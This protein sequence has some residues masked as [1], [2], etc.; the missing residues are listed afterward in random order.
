MELYKGYTKNDGKKPLDKIK[1]VTSFRSL[2]EVRTFDSYGG[3][4]AD[5]VVLIDVDDPDQSEILMKIVE[6]FQI[7]CKVI[8][9]SR[10]RHFLF[11]ND[12]IETNGTG[13]KL[14]C[15]LT[16]DIKLGSKNTVQ[17]LKINGLERFVEWDAEPPGQYDKIPKWL[18]PVSTSI[19]FLNTETRNEDLFRY[20]LVLQSQ[21][22][23]DKDQIKQT[24][25]IINDFILKTPLEQSEL[26]VIMRDEAFEKPCFM[27]G[28]KFLHDEFSKW[29]K[30][31]EHIKRINGQLCVYR[32]GVYMPGYKEIEKAIVKHIPDS[33][34]TQRKEVIKY[35]EII[36]ADNEPMADPRFI[37]FK[38]GIY[39]I[40][41]NS[42]LPFSPDYVITNKIP[43]N[44][45]PEAYS[46]LCDTVLNKIACG[47]PEIRMLL[48]ECI[49]ACFYRSNTLGGGK[50]FILTGTGANGKSTYLE[51]IQNVL[52]EQNYSSLGIDELAGT[53]TT[54]TMSG[55]LA[56]IGDDISDEFLSGKDVALFK[57]LIT[58]NTIMSQEKNQPVYFW[59]PYLKQLFSANSIPRM[60]DRSGGLALM[61]RLIII[62]FNAVF[63]KDDPDYDP[64]ISFKLNT[65]EVMEYLVKLGVQGLRRIIENNGFTSC[66]KVEKE[67]AEYEEMNNPIVMFLKEVEMD[68]ILNHETKE[69]HLRYD[70]FCNQNN[71]QRIGLATFSKEM[72]KRLGIQIVYKRIGSKKC[73]IFSK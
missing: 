65:K 34:D 13:K 63:S 72:T 46:E 22:H 43:H 36:C 67:L 42:M 47:D 8:Q 61:R 15:G 27:E 21:L 20:I 64:Y 57:K 45:N 55:K 5:N 17:C 18:F 30:E 35:L 39:D 24:L 71:F 66:E 49:G 37:A 1:G 10:G 41:T 33:R 38:N 16:A 7:N 25:Q 70:S 9:T 58:G 19:D 62:P 54:T 23:L 48:E 6:H 53:F 14:A 69:V 29:L 59:K 68:E 56:N 73:R 52:G 12:G 40:V 11:V 2:D 51:M 32:D 4:L 26:E 28:R 44:Y 3:V 31:E 60:R 50:A